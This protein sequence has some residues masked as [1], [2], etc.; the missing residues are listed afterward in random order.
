MYTQSSKA[1]D[2]TSQNVQSEVTKL[3]KKEEKQMDWREFEE[4]RDKIY[5][6]SSIAEQAGFI[7]GFKYGVKLMAECFA[8]GK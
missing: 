8:D 4:Y 6:V 7:K 3:L 1:N 2:Q 5:V